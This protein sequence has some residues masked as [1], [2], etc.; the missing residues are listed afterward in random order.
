[1]EKRSQQNE[2]KPPP[3]IIA[4]TGAESTGKST[5]TEALAKHYHVPFKPEYARTYIHDLLRKY[6]FGDLE[7]IARKQIEQYHELL[8]SKQPVVIL[9]TWL[10]ITKIWFDVVFGRIPE[11][12][13]KSITQL[14]I[15]LYLVCDTDLPWIADDV[16]ENGGENRNWLQQR[17]ISEIETLGVAYRIIQG[18]DHERTQNAISCIDRLT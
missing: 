10:L 7:N 11:W 9:D 4:V 14:R 15:D 12:L 13:E 5:L 8:A 2:L 17:Y 18:K 6:T 3:K 1:M 16:R